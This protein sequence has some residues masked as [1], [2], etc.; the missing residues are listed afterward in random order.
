MDPTARR[1]L[2]E[3]YKNGY[4]A[5]IEALHGVT[6]T[7][8]DSRPAPTE[9][10]PRQV[11]HH[12]A[13]S[14]MTS[15]IRLRRLLAEDGPTCESG[16]PTR[17]PLRSDATA[18]GR[19][20]DRRGRAQ[21]VPSGDA[22]V[23]HVPAV[24]GV[25]PNLARPASRVD[26]LRPGLAGENA[27][28]LEL[29]ER[30]VPWLRIDDDRPTLA[31][32]DHRQLLPLEARDG[33]DAGHG[34]QERD[35]LVVVDLVEEPLAGRFDVHRGR[36]QVRAPDRHRRVAPLGPDRG[37]T[38]AARGPGGG[39]VASPRRSSR[40]LGSPAR[41]C[42]STGRGRRDAA[43]LEG[44]PTRPASLRKTP[45]AISGNACPRQR[46]APAR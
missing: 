30:V 13:D 43:V 37:C 44:P 10:S 46:P 12:L 41:S 5:V 15:A 36:E 4:R 24:S 17:G 39:V 19:P 26:G 28:P 32:N 11:V 22:P 6:E 16:S 9:W 21:R 33:D 42:R 35:V 29:I 40:P 38:D 27:R 34:Q 7:E 1:A 3:Q 31:A 18:P 23:E 2:V 20:A 45:V 14:E 8:L 25:G